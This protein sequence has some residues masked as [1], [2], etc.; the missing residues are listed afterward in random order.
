MASYTSHYN[1]K[2][3]AGSEKVQI[4]DI[5]GNMDTLDT[6][7]YSTNQAI[8]N[9]RSLASA[10]SFSTL[11]GLSEILDT[12]ASNTTQGTIKTFAVTCTGTV[13]P[14]YNSVAYSVTMQRPGSTTYLCATLYANS[15]NTMV[16]AY[17]TTNGWTYK[18]LA[19]VDDYDVKSRTLSISDNVSS[20]TI[21]I[22]AN[23]RGVLFA[24][25]SSTARCWSA[26]VITFSSGTVQIQQLSKGEGVTFDTGT[27][28]KLKVTTTTAGNALIF[29]MSNA[30]LGSL[31]IA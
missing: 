12:Q 7:L 17:R 30:S 6:E 5:N 13:L 22:P 11:E 27:S 23:F 15:V 26:I 18:Q 14:F 8:A 9:V 24:S 28:G 10:G 4:G 25:T 16:F 1:L 31:S 3:P 20:Y 19:S 21:N 2:K 29:A